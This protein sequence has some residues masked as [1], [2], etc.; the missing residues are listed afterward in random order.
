MLQTQVSHCCCCVVCSP[1]VDAA[2]RVSSFNDVLFGTPSRPAGGS[3]G[4]RRQGPSM[5]GLTWG[6][7]Q[8]ANK[9][10]QQ[11]AQQQDYE[12]EEEAAEAGGHYV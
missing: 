8:R 11:Q 4:M 12:S 10:M 1:A 5:A 7:G 6:L 3:K 2:A 9:A